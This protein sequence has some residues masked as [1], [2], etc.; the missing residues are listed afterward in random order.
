MVSGELRMKQDRDMAVQL[1][2]LP[3]FQSSGDRHGFDRAR[4]L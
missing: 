1:L 4:A 2:K 3:V